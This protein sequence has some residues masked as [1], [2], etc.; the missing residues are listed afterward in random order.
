MNSTNIKTKNNKILMDLIECEVLKREGVG[1]KVELFPLI[2]KREKYV[3]KISEPSNPDE[4]IWELESSK[5]LGSYGK[6]DWEIE[7]DNILVDK[8]PQGIIIEQTIPAVLLDERL[9]KSR[10]KTATYIEGHRVFLKVSNEY[11]SE[12]FKQIYTDI[13]LPFRDRL[14]EKYG[15]IL[16]KV[17]FYIDNY[18]CSYN[19]FS[20]C[21]HDVFNYDSHAWDVWLFHD[22][23]CDNWENEEENYFEVCFKDFQMKPLSSVGQM[24]G[25]ALAI[26]EK[27][28]WSNYSWN[29][30]IFTVSREISRKDNYDNIVVE[31]H[32]NLQDW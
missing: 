2:T 7:L 27:L 25:M 9:V 15:H 18:W 5:S 31:F 21:S 6:P 32:K 23:F 24:Y 4:Y 14:L 20:V 11:A 29:N 28:K 13:G 17:V 10:R 12:S 22:T 1:F 19:R 8:L 3:K 16:N 30:C 26:I